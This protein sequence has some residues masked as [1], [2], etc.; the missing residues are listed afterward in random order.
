MYGLK[1]NI[2]KEFDT[3]FVISRKPL[4]GKLKEFCFVS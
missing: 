3:C 1:L 2:K 4:K